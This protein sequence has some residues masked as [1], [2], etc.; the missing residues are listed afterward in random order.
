MHDSDRPA[1]EGL[2]SGGLRFGGPVIVGVLFAVVAT[3]MS[4]VGLA[5]DHNLSLRNVGLAALLGGGAWGLVSWAIAT[6][7]VEVEQDVEARRDEDGGSP[8]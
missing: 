3:V 4:A 1:D 7:V 8:G 5:R 2:R 6:A